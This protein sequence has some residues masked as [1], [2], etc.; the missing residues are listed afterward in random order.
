MV[1]DGE[2]DAEVTHMVQMG[3]RTGR[4]C[5]EWRVTRKMNVKIKRMAYR[6]A[7]TTIMGVRS[8]KL[9]RVRN[10]RT[11]GQRKSETSQRKCMEGDLCGTGM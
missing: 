7:N 6:N 8:Y 5:L 9:D 10:E 3:G 4:E 11:N 1:K 2:L